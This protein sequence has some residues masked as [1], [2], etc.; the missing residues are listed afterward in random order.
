[1]ELAPRAAAEWEQW[2]CFWLRGLPPRQWTAFHCTLPAQ[3]D[4]QYSGASPAEPMDLPIGAVLATDGSGGTFSSE[5]RL[6]RCGWGFAILDPS[7]NL[8]ASGSGPLTSWRQTVPLAE[9]EAA[10]QLALSTK[11]D[12]TFHVDATYVLR[13]VRRGSA[14]VPKRHSYQ[15]QR[16]WAAVGDR[17]AEALK[18]AA[19]K[20]L[21][22][23]LQEGVDPVAWEANDQADKLAE[24]A[25]AEAQLPAEAVAAV[26]R[27]DEEA[28]RV[29]LHLAAVALHVAKAAPSLYGPSS[30]LQRRAE[31][32]NRARGKQEE[33]EAAQRLTEHSVDLTTGRCTKCLRGPT[34]ALPKLLFLRSACEGRPHELHDSHAI[35]LTRGL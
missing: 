5:P 8:L 22:Q 10:T 12:L 35:R 16:F 6:R 28:R 2:P 32:A 1:M 34:A 30:R 25:A 3:G 15:W 7:G 11:G 27:L 26:Q 24:R 14:S 18:I 19:H 23:A 17:R 31:A 4:A 20:T 33:L 21:D 9:L 29:Q 13:G